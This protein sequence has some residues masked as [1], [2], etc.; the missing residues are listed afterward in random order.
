MVSLFLL[1][2]GD[3]EDNKACDRQNAK[4]VTKVPTY[5]SEYQDGYD[6]D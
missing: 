6:L 2:H 1:K 5:L 4:T 3:R